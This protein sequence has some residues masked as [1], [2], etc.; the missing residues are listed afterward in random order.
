MT[1][2]KAAKIRKTAWQAALAEGRV[3]KINNGETMKSFPT[4]ELAQEAIMSYV[5][6]GIKAEVVVVG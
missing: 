6:S 1:P 3:I 4:I 2:R 5:A